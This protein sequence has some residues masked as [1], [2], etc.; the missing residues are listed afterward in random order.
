MRKILCVVGTRPEAIK[1]APVLQALREGSRARVRLLATAQH[2]QLLDQVLG[3]FGIR[4][5]IDLDLMQE[6]QTLAALSARLLEALDGVLAEEKPDVVVAQGDTTTALITALAS[7]YRE[8]PFGHVEAGLRTGKLE[9]PFPEEMNRLLT[10]RL[11]CWHFAPTEAARSNLLGEGVP[12]EKIYLTGNTVIDALLQTAARQPTLD[13]E[14]DRSKKLLLVTAHRRENFGP[15]LEEVF[16][17]LCSL[18]QREPDIEILYPL[19]PNPNAAKAA[20]Q[21]LAGRERI[22]LC[23]PL[24]YDAFVAAMSR[25][26]LILTD[27]G[28]IQEEAPALATPVLVLRDET[29]RTEAVQAGVARLVGVDHDRILAECTRLLHRPEAYAEMVRGES[30]YGD[31]KSAQ[32]IAEVLL[33]P[34][35]AQGRR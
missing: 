15:R 35:G 24:A 21:A 18:V 3:V 20:R 29:E 13:V 7:F 2:R 16:R 9:R 22:V 12:R 4:A 1:M 14:L 23:E 33:A 34:R 11:A 32:R 26:Y 6:D 10:S 17:A 8:I 27:S 31:G 5:D 30:P 25:A 28:G 19:H